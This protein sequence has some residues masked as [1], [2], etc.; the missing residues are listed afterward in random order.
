MKRA[1]FR[2]LACSC[3]IGVFTSQIA[4]GQADLVFVGGTI[5]TADPDQPMAEAIALEGDR[6]TALGP[7]AEIR[8]L[9]GPTTGVVHLGGRTLIPGLIDAHV[10][11]LVA[12]DVI[13][14]E[15]SLRD[16]ERMT[17]PEVMSSFL[18]HGITTVRSTGDPLPYIAEL[19]DRM[20]GSTAGPRVVITG[21]VPSSPGG[22]P[23]TT[24]CRGNLFCRHTLAREIENEE[25][26]RQAVQ[27][28]ARAN[29]DAVKIIV[30]E[31]AAEFLSLDS[32]RLSDEIVAALVEEAHRNNL[33]II[34]HVTVKEAIP[35]VRRLIEL[36]LDGFV[37]DP[38]SEARVPDPAEVVSVAA[39][40]RDAEIPV[41]TT[42]SNFDTFRDATGAE[43]F[44]VGGGT[45]YTPLLSGV[46]E[47]SLM[48]ARALEDAGVKLVV[49]T[50]WS[51]LARAADSDDPRRLP[52]ARTIHEME[53]L[54]RAGLPVSSILAAATANAA[55]AVGIGTEVGTITEGKLADLVI[56]DGNLLEDFSALQRTVAV[57]KEGQLASGSLR[58][59]GDVV[60]GTTTPSRH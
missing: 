41:T 56:L 26:T 34:A 46:F 48:S 45:P 13:V 8:R 29:V 39:M 19:R 57:F 43:R 9:A 33:R 60:E 15:A 10:H 35:V 17:L 12:P 28:L 55:E 2:I 4:M 7:D 54:R 52:G 11:L 53:L 20:A 44:F 59:L 37:H 49:G 36:G 58:N 25:Q 32:P 3:L 27:E 6:I 50:D 14:D 42:I 21:P 18:S 16:Y 24:V 38:L 23:A 47:A 22:H 31:L 40:L 1:L 5:L 51:G 30:D